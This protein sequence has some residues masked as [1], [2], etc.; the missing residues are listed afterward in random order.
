M[1]STQMM[2]VLTGYITGAYFLEN[3][4]EKMCKTNPNRKSFFEYSLGK[5]YA[6]STE[7]ENCV[8]QSINANFDLC[9]TLANIGANS[10]YCPLAKHVKL[11]EQSNFVGLLPSEYV[12]F[13][14]GFGT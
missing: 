1:R 7:L 14:H 3:K 4:L 6:I 2:L 13:V 5:I 8:K 11:H 12:L 10:S 9:L